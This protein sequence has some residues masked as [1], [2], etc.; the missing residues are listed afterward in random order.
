MKPVDLPDQ[1]QFVLPRSVCGVL[2]PNK[3]PHSLYS[4][5]NIQP[6]LAGSHSQYES[7]NIRDS[8]D[9]IPV[10]VS[11][12]L[13]DSVVHLP[14]IEDGNCHYRAAGGRECSEFKARLAGVE[15]D[16]QDVETLVTELAATPPET[17]SGKIAKL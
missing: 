13:S 6:R 14:C 3:P 8:D 4:T 10:A 9:A 16:K 5:S 11:Y 2:V 15:L 12:Q 17:V 1:R 7:R